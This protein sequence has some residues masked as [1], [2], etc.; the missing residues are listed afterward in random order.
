VQACTDISMS[1][2][3][4]CFCVNNKP[5]LREM[6]RWPSARKAQLADAGGQHAVRLTTYPMITVISGI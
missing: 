6:T 2:R 1:V 4:E 5:F 3:Q